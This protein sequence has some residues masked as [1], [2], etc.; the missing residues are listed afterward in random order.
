MQL[1]KIE[2]GHFV[3]RVGK[4][5]KA[6]LLELLK[7]YPVSGPASYQISKTADPKEVESDQA[8]LEEALAE[9]KLENQRQVQAMLTSEGRFV[10]DGLGYRFKLSV[11]QMEWLLQVLNDIRGGSWM[12]LGSPDPK[13]GRSIK[14]SEENLKLAWAMEMSGLYENTLL[15]ALD[16]GQ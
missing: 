12:R 1:L 10:E 6:V 15:E 16:S 5:E 8:L 9:H 3:F 11:H 2:E 13:N 14:L 7:R 4:R